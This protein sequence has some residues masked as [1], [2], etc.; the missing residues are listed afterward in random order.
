MKTIIL[1]ILV[2]SLSVFAIFLN[3]CCPLIL[4]PSQTLL[5][6]KTG[7]ENA[8]TALP[9]AETTASTVQ[10]ENDKQ[11]DFPQD[12]AHDLIIV[13]Y[14]KQGDLVQSPLIIEGE[15][16][17]TWYFEADFPVYLFDENGKELASH[18]AVA[19]DEW[20]TE[21]FVPFISE[22]IFEKPS[23][24][25]GVLVLQKSNPTG[26]AEFD[27]EIRITVRFE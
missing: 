11:Q 22:I 2:L 24:T 14:P 8:G 5:P 1:I 16:R 13:K 4:Q 6:E 27:D 23:T 9:P 18:Y 7:E 17:G 15:A 21:D 26:L 3:A 25:K 19:Q 12:T 10:E 20:M